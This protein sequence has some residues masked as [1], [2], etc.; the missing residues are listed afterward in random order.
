MDNS[1]RSFLKF[2]GISAL[3]LGG[4]S[5]VAGL[6]PGPATAEQG[7]S[8]QQFKDTKKA[9]TAG[10][11]GMVVD[12]RKLTRSLCEKMIAACHKAHNVPDHENERHTIKWLWTDEFAHVFPQKDDPYLSERLRD[13][14]LLSLCNQCNNPP[15][16]QACPTQATFQRADGIVMM[17]FHRC[18]G[19]R[20]CMAACP[21][22]SR[23][24]NFRDPRPA[25]KKENEDFPT[26][27]KGVVEKCNFCAER[28]AEGKMPACVEVSEGALVFGDLEDPN[29]EIRKV[30]REN[31]TI[32]RKQN[33]GTN[34]SVYYIV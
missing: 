3:G 33:L 19:C 29:S 16:V 27:M 12:T 25:I 10:R 17:D 18:I 30:L 2:A 22:G 13:L 26:R 11:W 21:Y 14:P 8:T 4:V 9:L 6:L 23:S 20:F 5:T 7:T 34:P 15:C 28:L 31:Y 24:F 32:R 1:R